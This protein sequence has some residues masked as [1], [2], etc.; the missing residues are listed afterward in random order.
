MW[1][2]W[3]N[4]LIASQVRVQIQNVLYVPEL[5]ESL[6]STV[7][8]IENPGCAEVSSDKFSYLI[9]PQH[10][11][12]AC[13]GSSIK[14]YISEGR[15]SS[16]P[17]SFIAQDTSP[18][19]NHTQ[20]PQSHRVLT[21]SSTAPPSDFTRS[22]TPTQNSPQRKSVTFDPVPRPFPMTVPGELSQSPSKSLIQTIPTYPLMRPSTSQPGIG[23]NSGQ[24][25][26]KHNS[27]TTSPLFWWGCSWRHWV[28]LQNCTPRIQI[29]L[30]PGRS[31]YQV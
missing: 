10:V 12:Q 6:F 3:N 27:S 16:L 26:Q 8:H 2:L 22:K 30:A 28:Q 11:I 31:G 14:L 9:F 23:C 18:V 20:K 21:R 17:V 5:T 29:H 25:S 15:K 7:Q 19:F 1:W 24:E 13:M 4:R